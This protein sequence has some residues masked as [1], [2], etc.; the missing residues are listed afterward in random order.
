MSVKVS[1]WVWEHSPVSR[2][3]LLVL[4]ALADHAQDNGAGAYPSVATIAGKRAS[5]AV[6]RSS[7]YDASS[8]RA[9]SS[10]RAPAPT[11]RSPTG[12]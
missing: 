1:S 8:S 9:P 5:A 6:A 11:G 3:D 12:S 7:R 4:V 10:R 2:G